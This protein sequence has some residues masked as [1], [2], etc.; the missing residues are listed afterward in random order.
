M[1]RIVFV[2]GN[3]KNG[4]VPM[5]TTNLANEFAKQGY[6]STI[7]V[8]K[9]IAENVFFEHHENVSIVS[10]KEYVSAH[11][12]DKTV[13]NNIKKRNRNCPCSFSNYRYIRE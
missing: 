7:L 8:T 11:L 9:D 4:G 5:R 12:N 13:K 3:Y 2:I 1:K 10:L 6:R